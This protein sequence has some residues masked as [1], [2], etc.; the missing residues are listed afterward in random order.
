M[1]GLLDVGRLDSSDEAHVWIFHTDPETS[2]L[3]SLLTADEHERA[4]RFH[5]ARDRARFITRRSYVRRLLAAYLCCDATDVRFTTT[6]TGKPV[7]AAPAGGLQFSVSQSGDVGACI[8]G[9]GDELGIDVEL[10]QEGV[11]KA[12]APRV[13]T[14]RERDALAELRAP[15]GVV[16]FFTLWTHK[17]AMLKADGRG[18]SVDVATV[19]VAEALTEGRA[20]TRLPGASCHSAYISQTVRIGPNVAGAV[21]GEAPDLT[22]ITRRFPTRKC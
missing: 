7:V 14:A 1:H 15:D 11:V 3:R 16:A 8:I 19:D 18:L 5:F 2:A 12:L 13:C 9:R 22:V 6:R 21:A 10:I 17:E 20:H 4:G